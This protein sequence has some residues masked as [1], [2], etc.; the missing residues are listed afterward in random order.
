V[1]LP[2]LIVDQVEVR[3]I[4]LADIRAGEQEL[5]VLMLLDNL[6]QVTRILEASEDFP[7]SD[8]D[9]FL[10]VVG[11]LFG[12][13]EIFHVRRHLDFQFTAEAE[14]MV[15]GIPAG[16]NDGRVVQDFDF[17]LSEFLYGNG[18]DLNE[19][20]EIDLNRVFLSDFKIR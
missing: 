7:L 10:E 13:A 16:E 8:D 6:E 5:F 9:V 1:R 2:A 12:D 19:R 17:L 11:S 4:V 18:F 3:Y 14:E 20:T 15:Y